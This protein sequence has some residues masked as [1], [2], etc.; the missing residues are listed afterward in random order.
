MVKIK[1]FTLAFDNLGGRCPPV[2]Y[3]PTELPPMTIDYNYYKYN[4]LLAYT[5][6]PIPIGLFRLVE[7]PTLGS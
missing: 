4:G 1:D 6:G 3:W 2:P 7:N 5:E